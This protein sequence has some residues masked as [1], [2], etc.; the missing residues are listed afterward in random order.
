MNTPNKLTILRMILVI[1]LIVIFCL[2]IWYSIAIEK[3]NWNDL[4]NNKSNSQYFLYSAGIIFIISMLT[5][6]L[7]GYLARKNNQITTFGKFFDPLSDKII[8][9]T[10]LI[11]LTIIQS[12]YLILV[13]L[14]II[15]DLVVDGSRNLAASKQIKIEANIWGK[16][17]TI[18]QSIAIPILIFI[19][20]SINHS[21]WWQLFLLNIPLIIATLMSLFSGWIYFKSIIPY[22]KEDK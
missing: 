14:F 3:N 18:F 7:D 15:R 13:I 10:T 22:L 17:K 12:T 6:L 21:I 2:F 19:F 5:D 1:P 16:L 4:T 20:P 8:I 11:F 9:T